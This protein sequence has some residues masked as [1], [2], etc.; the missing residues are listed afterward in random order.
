MR[1]HLRSVRLTD[2]FVDRVN[3]KGIL[4]AVQEGI[5]MDVIADRLQVSA[6]K[7][8]A[9]NEYDVLVCTPVQ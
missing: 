7:F 2:S 9:L 3:S 4:A 1:C 6:A 5:S 8:N